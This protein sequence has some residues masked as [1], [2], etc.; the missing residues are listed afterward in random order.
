MSILAKNFS[1]IDR[2]NF[3]KD[4]FLKWQCRV[5]QIVM[6]DNMGKPESS[7][8]PDVKLHSN[9]EVIGKIITVLSKEIA[10][11]RVPEMQHMAKVTFDLSK[12]REKA[13]QFFS[14][15]YF[16]KHKEFSDVLTATFQPG[17]LGAAKIIKSQNCSLVFD[18]YN[19]Y[20]ELVCKVNVL[21]KNDPFYQAT[22]WHN[23]LFNPNLHPETII[24]AFKADWSISLEKTDQQLKY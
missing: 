19:Q 21:N 10:F 12:R 3:I 7:I 14:E 23:K 6:R 11:S 1:D 16:Q 17:S 13:I 24:L 9:E 15:Y 4:K 22:W 20:F 18:A 2:S 5:R 8:M